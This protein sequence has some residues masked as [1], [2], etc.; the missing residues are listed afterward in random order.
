MN[1]EKSFITIASDVKDRLTVDGG[2]GT[3][4]TTGH[5]LSPGAGAA[6]STKSGCCGK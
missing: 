2:T 4:A 1:V 3:A 5:K 6:S